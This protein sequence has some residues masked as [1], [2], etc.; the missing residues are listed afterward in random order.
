[1]INKILLWVVAIFLI[2]F[3]TMV[4]Y[5]NIPGEAV[6]LNSKIGDTPSVNL[7]SKTPMFL[8]NMRFDHNNISYSIRNNCPDTRIS[9]M[10]KAFE[11]INSEVNEISFYETG[12][13]ADITISCLREY[14]E[15]DN[16]FF[17]AGEGGPV[18][19]LRN[20]KFNLI[21]KGMIYLYRNS[22]CENPSVELHELLHVFGFAHSVDPKNIMYN[23]S[24]CSQKLSAE[25]IDTLK[26]LYSIP[27]L[28]DAKFENLS[29]VTKGKFFD[30]NVTI[31][32]DGLDDIENTNLTLFSDGV[33]IKTI[34]I[35]NLEMGFAKT[36]YLTNMKSPNEPNTIDFYIDYEN[37]I[38][39]L[40]E[41]NNHA[42]AS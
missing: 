12:K 18:E 28:P 39:E 24:S 27:L 2:V 23:I 16:N 25:I 13:D 26:N 40:D 10:K 37:T 36:L 11:T 17:T 14:I 4:I 21:S 3:T 34:D 31:I 42:K 41:N 8:E 9:F 32:N 7:S 22:V 38:E 30:F 20:G 5:E 1:M 6:Q 29:V 19:I 33:K 15:I 35:G